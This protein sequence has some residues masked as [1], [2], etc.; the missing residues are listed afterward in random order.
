[1]TKELTAI[2]AL[3]I[4]LIGAVFTFGTRI[5]T[6]TERVETQTKQIELLGA[7]LRA[8]NQH[9]VI[10]AGTHVEPAPVRRPPPG[11]RE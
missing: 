1:M 11:R 4:T 9:F 10:W 6:L 3:L 8:I 7:D 2:L 5:G